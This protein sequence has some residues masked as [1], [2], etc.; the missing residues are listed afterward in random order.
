MSLPE[1]WRET[2]LG[3]VVDIIG[4]GTPKTSISDY[5][6]G[7][8]PWLSV[9]DFNDDFRWVNS[10]EKTI[11]D[12]GLNNSSTKLLNKGDLIISA[13]GTVGALAQLKKD[14]AFNQSC[15]GIKSIKNTSYE[16]FLYYLTKYSLRQISSKTHGAV[17][18]TI[19][20]QTFDDINIFFPPL[21]EQKAIANILSSLDTKIELL[22]EQNETL[23]QMAQGVFREWFVDGVDDGWDIVKITDLFEVRDGTHDSPKQKEEGFPL[24]TSKH[25]QNFKL[26][27]DSA[28]LISE[29]DYVGINKRSLVEKNDILFSMIGTIGLIYIEQ[30]KEINYAIKNVALFKTS[31]NINW[32]FYT[33]LWMSGSNGKLFITEYTSGSTQQ[34]ISL[35]NLRNITFTKP[36]IDILQSFNNII[37]PLFEKIKNNTNQI[38][39]L[40]KTR[41]TLLPKLMSGEIRVGGDCYRTD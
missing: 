34:Y 27:I 30:S 5:W 14:M 36:P 28:Y 4:G 1:G 2:T 19:T 35:T 33:Y 3:E 21:Q 25:L 8:I 31:Q 29:E 39:T 6:Q 7:K 16:D 40:Q 15:Y 38:Q 17:F 10:T 41:D 37:S 26:D 11:T 9:V 20:K 13:R 32:C 22:K 23:E 24:I 18:D 12:K